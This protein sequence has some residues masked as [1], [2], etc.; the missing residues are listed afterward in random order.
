VPFGNGVL[1]VCTD[2]AVGEVLVG[3]VAGSLEGLFLE[4]TVVCVVCLDEDAE[5]LAMPFEGS[6]GSECL[7]GVGGGVTVD[8]NRSGVLVNEEGC[9]VEFGVHEFAFELRDESW[10]SDF[11]LVDGNTRAWLG[12]RSAD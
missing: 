9:A 10:S 6:L 8:E 5:R 3:F 7:F 1:M 2:A 4:A 11:K 12:V